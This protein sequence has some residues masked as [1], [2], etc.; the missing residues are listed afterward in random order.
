MR[1]GNGKDFDPALLAVF[2]RNLPAIREIVARH[3]DEPRGGTELGVTCL[4]SRLAGLA[5]AAE[6]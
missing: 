4:A 3:P 1:H 5:A 2:F 6:V